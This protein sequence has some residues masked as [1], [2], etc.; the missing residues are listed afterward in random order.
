MENFGSI[1]F[2]GRRN[3]VR[4]GGRYIIYLPTNMNE[5]WRS[6]HGRKVLVIIRA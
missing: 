6:L 2:A 3:V 5:L 1:L 4:Q